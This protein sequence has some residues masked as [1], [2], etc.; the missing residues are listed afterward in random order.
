MSAQIT[1]KSS[2]D[3][4]QPLPP[5]P[6]GVMVDRAHK[7]VGVAPLLAEWLPAAPVA[8]HGKLPALPPAPRGLVDLGPAGALRVTGPDRESWLQGMQTGDL[9]AAPEGGAAAGVFLGTRGKTVA[10]GLLWRFM[11]SVV[12]TVRPDRVAP[13]AAHLDK[14]LIMEDAELAPAP[15]LHRL[16]FCPGDVHAPLA[17]SASPALLAALGEVRGTPG[18]LGFELLV[19]EAQAEALLAAI[20]ERPTDE[21]LERW[22][23]ALGVPLSGKDFEEETNPL[24]AGLDG[25]ISFDKGCYVGQEVIAMATY[26]GRVQWNLV[27]LE[28]EGAPPAPGTPLEPARGGKGKVTSA[29]QVGAASLLLGIVHRE[30]IVPGST[31]PLPEG[32]VATVL[33]LPFGSRPGAGVCE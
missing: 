11:D 13:L 15:G 14:L 4:K 10:D 19:T 18:P 25:Q 7:A 26:R 30:R 20:P 27:R 21:A 29:V 1:R 3:H 6:P 24:E 2:E 28:V 16:R 23:V 8:S 5:P 32:R 9:Q 33:G 12:A 17:R 22:R 31:V